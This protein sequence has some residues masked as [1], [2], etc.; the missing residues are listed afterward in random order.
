MDRFRFKGVD[1]Q[2]S[3]C[4]VEFVHENAL[5]TCIVTELYPHNPGT[6]VIHAWPLLIEQITAYYNLGNLNIR[7]IEHQPGRADVRWPE[8][9]EVVTMEEDNGIRWTPINKDVIALL[10]GNT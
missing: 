10:L 5:V 9:W 6:L 8:T 4:G 3:L 1:R 7:W 2:R